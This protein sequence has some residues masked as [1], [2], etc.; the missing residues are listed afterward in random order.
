MDNETAAAE[1]FIDF[2]CP[3]CGEPVSFPTTG[4]NSLQECF[5]CNEPIIVLKGE[6]EGRRVSLPVTTARLTLR[7]FD[8]KDWKGLVELFS[9]EEF[10]SAA[11]MKLDGE[12]QVTRWLESDSAVKLTTRDA[13]YVLA[14]Q[15]TDGGKIIGCLTLSIQDAERLQAV[16]NIVIHRNYQR[17]GYGTEA[18][19]GALNFCLASLPFHRVQAFCDSASQAGCRLLEKAGLRRE[20]EFVRDHK[21]RG[22]WASTAAFAMLREELTG[23]AT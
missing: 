3:H 11:P 13:P 20:G 17:K 12:E 4:G 19:R 14:V 7:R 16:L 21:V 10:F 9:D 5:N 23:S 1:E 8:N 22:E 15:E 2:K 18:V 6:S